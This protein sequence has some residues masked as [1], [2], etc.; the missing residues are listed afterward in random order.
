MGK[1][2]LSSKQN[3]ILKFI[4]H[5]IESRPYPPSIRDIQDGCDLSSTSVVDYNLK[6]LE[7]KNYLKRDTSISRGIYLENQKHVSR[8]I[9]TSDPDT[10]M[11]QIEIDDVEFESRGDSRTITIPFLGYISAG[12]PLSIPPSD[13]WHSNKLDNVEIPAFLQKGNNNLFALKV[14]GDSMIDALVTEG[15]LIIMEQTTHAQPGDMVAA[16]LSDNQEVTL[17]YFQMKNDKVILRPA[18]P[19]M[20]PIEVPANKVSIQGKIVGLIRSIS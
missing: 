16:W 8:P 5:F 12:E 17:K 11:N 15:D 20:S 9:E 6:I 19:T 4:K 2:I 1:N 13:K 14:K 10:M 7:E 3:A 18:N